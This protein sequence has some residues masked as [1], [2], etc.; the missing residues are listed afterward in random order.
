MWS[1]VVGGSAGLGWNKVG[2]AERVGQLY[3]WLGWWNIARL[4]A[5]LIVQSHYL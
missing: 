4:Q 2:G 3:A 5:P 1:D